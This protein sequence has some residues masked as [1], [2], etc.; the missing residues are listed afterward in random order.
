MDSKQ[1]NGSAIVHAS[2]DVNLPIEIV[3]LESKI[4][5]GLRSIFCVLEKE[6]KKWWN[7][8][9]KEGKPPHYVKVDWDKWVDEDDD[10]GAAEP[11]LGGMDF[12]K[13]GDMGG[14]GGMEGMMGGMGGMGGMEGMVGGMGGMSGMEGLMGGMGGMGGPDEFEDDSDDDGN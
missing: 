8:L 6:E 1:A 2:V 12:S 4:N 7:K 9:L 14:M 5:Y 13:F 11:D 3:F 10:T